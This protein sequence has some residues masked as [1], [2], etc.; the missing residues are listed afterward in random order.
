LDPSE[1]DE[2]EERGIYSKINIIFR[3]LFGVVKKTDHDGKD[4]K[5]NF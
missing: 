4:Q 2:L 3:K 5:G 1:I